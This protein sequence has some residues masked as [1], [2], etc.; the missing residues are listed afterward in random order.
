ML[1]VQAGL[2]HGLDVVRIRAFNHLGPGQSDMFVASALASRIAPPSTPGTP[3]FGSEISR[4]DEISPTFETWSG[5]I[6]R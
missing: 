2:G 1:C 3:R 6:G 4:R 5:P